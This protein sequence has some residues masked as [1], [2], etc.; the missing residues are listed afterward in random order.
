MAEP[1]KQEKPDGL[2]DAEWKKITA[3]RESDAT[4]TGLIC[5][6]CSTLGGVVAEL[7]NIGTKKSEA[8]IRC[9]NGDEFTVRPWP[10]RVAG[11]IRP[12]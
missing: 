12:A 11:P 5:P 2:T 7:R 4:P 10:P 9:D 8:T 3:Q 6:K 1:K